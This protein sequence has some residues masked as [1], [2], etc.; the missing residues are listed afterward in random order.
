MQALSASYE[1][2]RTC[3]VS[4]SKVLIWVTPAGFEK[5]MAEVGKR[6]DSQ[7]GPASLSPADLEK[8][9][10]TA[11]QYGIEIIPPPAN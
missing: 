8:I 3:R 11:P 5:F 4:K 7:V 2:N 1:I 6:A 10:S 9:L